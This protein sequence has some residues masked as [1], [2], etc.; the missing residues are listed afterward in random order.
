MYYLGTHKNPKQT[1]EIAYA[2]FEDHN[3]PFWKIAK[4]ALFNNSCMIFISPIIYPLD[5]QNTKYEY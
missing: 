4:M 1:V 3:V 5:K 2:L